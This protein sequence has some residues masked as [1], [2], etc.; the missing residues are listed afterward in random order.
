[1]TAFADFDQIPLY[2][3]GLIMADPPWAFANWGEPNDRS[4]AAHYGT[5]DLDGIRALPVE[6]LAA[7]NAW[8]VLW[9]TGAMLPQA[10][11]VM[12]AWGFTYVTAGH[13]TKVTKSS[14]IRPRIGTGHVLREA[15]EPFL[16]GRI[17]SPPVLDRGIPSVIMASRREHSRK[18]AEAE[19]AATEA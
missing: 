6:Q 12:A 16:I 10:F 4:A 15:G 19:P 14:P 2:K 8:L 1:M 7:P 11:E 9:A 3:Y 13:W 17:G 5:M 18:P